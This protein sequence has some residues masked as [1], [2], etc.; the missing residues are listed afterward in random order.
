MMN[1]QKMILDAEEAISQ[2]Q[3]MTLVV[4]RPFKDKPK[5]FPS[6]SLLCEQQKSNVNSYDPRK[7]LDWLKNNG[8]YDGD[9]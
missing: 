3:N 2:G 4:P 5:G 9:K 7:V 8:L 6:G 1:P